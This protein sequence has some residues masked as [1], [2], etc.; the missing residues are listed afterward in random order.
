ML[1]CV[2]SLCIL[3]CKIKLG[4]LGDHSPT[5]NFSNTYILKNFVYVLNEWSLAFM[6]RTPS[7][8]WPY[9]KSQERRGMEKLL[10]SRG[11][12]RR[13]DAVSL[14][15]FSS[16]GVAYVIT[17]TF[18]DILVIVFL[19]PLNVGV[20]PY[21]HCTVLVPFHRVYTSCFHNTVVS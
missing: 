13:G 1:L 21:F 18:N 7:G 2:I 14:V 17:V 15:I 9:Q 5:Q 12:L 11:I 8:D 3:D 16:W 10:K 19:F 20:S 4:I 6:V